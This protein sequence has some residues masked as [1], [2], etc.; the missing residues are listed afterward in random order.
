MRNYQTSYKF[1]T[2]FSRSSSFISISD[3]E[4]AK[5]PGTLLLVRNNVYIL[6]YDRKVIVNSLCQLGI[7]AILYD[8]IQ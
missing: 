3:P 7:V 8:V 4:H 2:S 5:Q 6:D 1:K